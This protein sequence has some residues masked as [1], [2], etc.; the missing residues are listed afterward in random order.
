MSVEWLDAGS[1]EAFDVLTEV[2]LRSGGS[3][4]EL[5]ALGRVRFCALSS[6]TFA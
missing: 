6:G 1:T 4:E 5:P 2:M 3:E